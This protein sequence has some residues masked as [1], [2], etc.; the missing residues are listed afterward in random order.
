[1]DLPGY[2]FAKGSKEDRNILRRLIG[3]YLLH[4]TIK[5]KKIVLIIDAKVGV[6]DLD[7]DMLGQLEE[8]EKDLIVVANQN[9]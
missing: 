3:W 9:W 7:L 8:A 4:P 6:T 2:G 5:Q 1:M